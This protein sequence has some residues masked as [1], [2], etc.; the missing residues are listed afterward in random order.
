M[1]SILNISAYKFVRLNDAHALRERLLACASTLGLKGTVLIAEEGINLFLAGDREAVAGFLRTL[2]ADARFADISPKESWSARQPFRKLLVKVKREI[3][4][5]NHPAIR[6]AAG[7][8]PAVDAITLKRWLDAGQDDEGRPVVTLDTRNAFEVDQGTFE[9][10]I[11]W[12]IHKFSEFPQAVQSHKHEL[13][14]KTVVS[15][16]TGGIRCEKAA[17]YLREAGVANVWQLE[18]GILKYFELA[19]GTHYRGD[20]FVFD[21]REALDPALAPRT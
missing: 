16:C 11:D 3:I 13:A 20:C 19:G 1:N 12:R 5:M 17:I 7:R 14:D 10:A 2:Q 4:R 15:F 18:G 21:E 8:A 6:P 9:G